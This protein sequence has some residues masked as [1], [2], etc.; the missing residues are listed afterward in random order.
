MKTYCENPLCENRSVKEVHVS[1]NKPADRTRAICATCEETYTWGVQHGKMTVQRVRLW[2]LAA[3]DAG[4][5]SYVSVCKSKFEVEKSL[6]DYL[7]RYH[8]YRGKYDIKAAYKWLREH[9]EYL[10]VSIVQQDF[11]SGE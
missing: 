8:D 1:V 7:R 2:V 5:I 10:S 9:D 3:A 11:N 6:L 4:V